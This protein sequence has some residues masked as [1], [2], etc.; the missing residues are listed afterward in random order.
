MATSHSNSNSNSH[1]H[2][3][4]HH[5]RIF[6]NHG[7]PNSHRSRNR[8]PHPTT[9]VLLMAT[10]PPLDTSGWGEP[11]ITV[12]PATTGATVPRSVPFKDG[13]SHIISGYLGLII[14]LTTSFLF[15]ILAQKTAHLN[16][17]GAMRVKMDGDEGDEGDRCRC[18]EDFG[19]LSST[20]Y[21]SYRYLLPMSGA[22]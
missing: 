16:V 6:V 2:N 9:T 14:L 18:R 13:A 15:L 7:P 4:P 5:H 10:D 11:E 3:F 20:S 12:Q 8:P 19:A 17:K 21:Q 22:C 1:S